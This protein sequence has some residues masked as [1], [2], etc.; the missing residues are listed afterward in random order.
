[1]I[2]AHSAFTTET[3]NRTGRLSALAKLTDANDFTTPKVLQSGS[4]LSLTQG[5]TLNFDGDF[6]M[7]E[8]SPPAFVASADFSFWSIASVAD[9]AVFWLAHQRLPANCQSKVFYATPI[10]GNDLAKRSRV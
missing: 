2:D 8:V 9:P 1:M 7:D 3:E 10:L 4:I 5:D 6:P